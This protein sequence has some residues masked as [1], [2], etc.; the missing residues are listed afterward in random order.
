VLL[1]LFT[2]GL[3]VGGLLSAT[4]LGLLSGL[5]TPVPLSWRY[6]V[7][8]LVAVLGLLRE[9]G[10]VTIR[11]PQ[12]ARQIGQ[13]VLQRNR[14]GVFQFGFELGTGVRTYVSATAPYVL[15]TALFLAGQ[16][17]RVALL[18]GFGFG[19]GR[20]L[21]PL[22]RRAA[23]DG[24]RWDADLRIRLRMITVGG[25]VVLLIALALL[26]IRHWISE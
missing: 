13:D 22:V 18:A 26:G 10:L 3:T 23:G 24:D 17:L 21:T 20:A 4:V 5:S 7:I 2:V 1:A 11:L 12:N 15:A 19:I 9:T 16:Q 8:V 25:S 6:A 14:R